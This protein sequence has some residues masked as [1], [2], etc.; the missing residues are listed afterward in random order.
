MLQVKSGWLAYIAA[1]VMGAAALAVQAE[2][3]MKPFILASTASG[4][5]ADQ[6]D[7][8]KSALGDKGFE[9]VGE[10][11]PYP[12][13]H[14]IVV[15]NEAL[16]KAAAS[17]DRAGYVAAQRV[18]ITKVGDQVQLAYT[19]PVY[20]GAAYRVKDDLSGVADALEAALGAEKEY[21][22]EEGLTA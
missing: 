9:V 3:E 2:G 7:G 16:K 14:I 6:I 22:P 17:H 5:I 8:V 19:N 13:A 12:A 21:G 10:Y 20:M 1:V 4:D 18:T 15:T 11:S